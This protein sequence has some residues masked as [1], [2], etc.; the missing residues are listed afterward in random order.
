M[1]NVMAV[2]YSEATPSSLDKKNTLL[3]AW[4]VRIGDGLIIEC[5]GWLW[6]ADRPRENVLA[7]KCMVKGLHCLIP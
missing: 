6:V 2:A 1:A 7:V 5:A 3:G 4:Q